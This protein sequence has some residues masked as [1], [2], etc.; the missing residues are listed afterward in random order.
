MKKILLLGGLRYLIPVI[1]SAHKFGYY[2]ITCDNVPSNI[3]HNYSDEYHNVSIL[4]KDKILQLAQELSIS[5]I[6]SFAVDPGVAT[7]AYVAEKMD[8]SFAGSY[9]S[10]CILQNKDLFRAFLTK[11]KFNVPISGGYADLK[12][13]TEDIDRFNFPIIVKPVDSAGSKGVNRV[14][15]IDELEFAVEEALR[16][17]FTKRI[18]VEEFI[19]QKG[20]S[21]DSDCFSINGQLVFVS[22]SDQLFDSSAINPYTPSAYIWPNSMTEENKYELKDELQRLFDLLKL[23]TSIY[24]IETRVGKDGKPYIMEVSPRGG[25][26]RISEILAM[27]T[28]INLIDCAVKASVG[29]LIDIPATWSYED[30]WCELIL[31][32]DKDGVFEDIQI[33]S[34]ISKYIVESD[35]WVNKGDVVHRFSGANETIGTLILKFTSKDEYNFIQKK[36]KSNIHIIVN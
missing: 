21:S 31:H 18:I 15:S 13:I 4:D 22:F 19:E 2:V 8:L 16:L 10:V 12:S 29:D 36:I 3:A 28:P 27:A 9:D 7:A 33:D 1:E 20:Y 5:G 14:D 25:G 23:K 6:M 17:S 30:I 26:N 24:N 32:S 34:S 35:I 11:H